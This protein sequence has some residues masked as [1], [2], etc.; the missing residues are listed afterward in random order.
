MAS[1]LVGTCSRRQGLPIGL[2]VVAADGDGRL[3]NH[4][5]GGV[6]DLSSLPGRHFVVISRRRRAW[7]ESGHG[8][9]MRMEA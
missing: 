2:R 9:E 6:F 4:S 7:T 3:E 5:K 8:L 1:N